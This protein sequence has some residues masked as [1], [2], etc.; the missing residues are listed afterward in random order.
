MVLYKL[1][2]IWQE[3]KQQNKVLDKWQGRWQETK[4]KIRYRQTG[5]WLLINC[6]GGGQRQHKKK[7]DSKNNE[8]YNRQRKTD[9]IGQSR[10]NKTRFTGRTIV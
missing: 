3:T 4:Q 8:Y 9:R 10:S 1:Q 7:Q 6:N 2:W 5:T